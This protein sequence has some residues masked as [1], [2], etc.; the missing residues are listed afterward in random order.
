MINLARS[1]E[2]WE[3]EDS[4]CKLMFKPILESNHP[5]WIAL[6]PEVNI[7]TQEINLLHNM[8]SQKYFLP[9]FENVLYP[10]FSGFYNVIFTLQSSPRTFTRLYD[11]TV[12]YTR[13]KKMGSDELID[14][15]EQFR[16]PTLL[17]CFASKSKITVQIHVKSKLLSSIPVK[18]SKI[19]KWLEKSWVDKDQRLSNEKLHKIS[20][21]MN[22]E[23]QHKDHV[24][25]VTP[26]E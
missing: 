14:L 12:W 13:E 8:Q 15:K 5:E 3:L 23:F 25:I 10:R 6:F 16:P 18:R 17:E 22:K 7:C 26:L 21:S 20:E 9:V 4:L 11:V 19:E 1:D 24:S 2:N